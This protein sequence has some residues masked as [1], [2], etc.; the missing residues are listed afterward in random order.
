M[1][2]KRLETSSR[3][4]ENGMER[5]VSASFIYKCFPEYI[6]SLSSV[7]E[8]IPRRDGYVSSRR[9]SSP[10]RRSKLSSVDER[11]TWRVRQ[12]TLADDR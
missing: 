7:D 3:E 4:R 11:D 12:E 6:E 2:M 9:E 10:S 5:D 1:G 8:G